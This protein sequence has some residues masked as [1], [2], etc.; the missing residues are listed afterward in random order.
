MFL[1]PL[2]IAS[3]ATPDMP[4][5]CI[6]P[7]ELVSLKGLRLAAAQTRAAADERPQELGGVR[8]T[9]NGA[10]LP[11]LMV[12]PDRI[13]ALI[14]PSIPP[15]PAAFQVVNGG[16]TSNTVEVEACVSGPAAFAATP[17]GLGI[18][19]ATHSDGSPVA[20]D[21]P[22][23]PGE[24]I[25][26]YVTGLGRNPAEVRILFDGNPG[27][28]QFA[29]PAPGLPGVD[30]INVTLPAGLLPRGT[31]ALA[32]GTVDSFSDLADLHVRRP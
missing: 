26:L 32:I 18:V 10:M 30:Q 28:V 2:G 12:S 4:A 14:P 17:A 5:I 11:L 24:T 19:K 22:V 29:G 21:R 7:G 15:G 27:E 9:L 3:Q 8:V 25:S 6:A 16:R 20:A 23:A 31:V 1:D 13:E